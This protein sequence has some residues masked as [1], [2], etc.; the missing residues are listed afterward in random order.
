MK[1]LCAILVFVLLLAPIKAQISV[2]PG[3]FPFTEVANAVIDDPALAELFVPQILD[4]LVEHPDEIVP[5]GISLLSDPSFMERVL[6]ALPDLL[7]LLPTVLLRL[8]EI[9]QNLPYLVEVLLPSMD[10]LINSVVPVINENPQTISNILNGLMPLL[11]ENM[12]MLIEAFGAALPVVLDYAPL[13]VEVLV[14]LSPALPSVVAQ[15]DLEGLSELLLLY[16]P[17]ISE[18]LASLF[19]GLSEEQILQLSELAVYFLRVMPR[20]LPDIVSVV[21]V[22]LFSSRSVFSVLFR[23]MTSTSPDEIPSIMISLMRVSYALVRTVLVCVSA[24][25]IGVLYRTAV[26]AAESLDLLSMLSAFR[27]TH[28]NVDGAIVPGWVVS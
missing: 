27:G 20:I 8:P 17:Q 12:D 18:S 6:E 21:P 22:L 9:L 25:N 23:L 14:K 4:A 16:L 7:Y 19:D 11:A 3:A 13:L 10:A 15:I 24:E 2:S 28:V 1:K 26:S 5:L